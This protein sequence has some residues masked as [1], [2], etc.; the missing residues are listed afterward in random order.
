MH[1][2]HAA[3][4]TICAADAADAK[5]LCAEPVP[6]AVLLFGCPSSDAL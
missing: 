5:M 6:D 3:Y 4:A 2:I 1:V